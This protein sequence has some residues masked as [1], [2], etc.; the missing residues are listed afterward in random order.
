MCTYI[1]TLHRSCSHKQ[2]QN[3]FK[4]VSARG[5]VLNRSL[6]SLTLDQT[7]HLPDTLPLEM[8]DPMCNQITRVATRP[9]EG[10]CR[11]CVRKE[12]EMRA[13][14]KDV[15]QAREGATTAAGVRTSILGLERLVAAT[16]PLDLDE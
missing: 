13:R 2:Y 8:P 1:L 3:T 11:A 5:S 14:E 9:V 12:R 6:G 10:Q 4:C 7:I 16:K 15:Q